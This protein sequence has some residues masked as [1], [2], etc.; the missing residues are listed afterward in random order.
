MTIAEKKKELRAQMNAKRLGLNKAWKAKYDNWVCH[1]LWQIIQLNNAKSVHTFLPMGNEINIYPLI[2][3]ML[4][5]GII[6]V[7]PKTLKNRKMQNLVLNSIDELEEGLFGTRHPKNEE[8]FEG[9]YNII[10][11]P[12]LAFDSNKNRL[13]Y[14]GGYYDS[15]IAENPEALRIGIFYPFQLLSKIPVEEH[16][17]KLDEVLYT[18]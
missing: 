11:V 9:N 2:E 15:F 5:E 10:I 6:V 12:G 18:N 4:K 7:C 14:G 1:A 13:G 3:V 8:I 17:A 16:D